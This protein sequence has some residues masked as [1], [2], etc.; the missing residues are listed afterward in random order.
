M[1][2]LHAAIKSLKFGK[3]VAEDL[4]FVHEIQLLYFSTGIEYTFMA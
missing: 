1:D 2:E 3:A 4:E